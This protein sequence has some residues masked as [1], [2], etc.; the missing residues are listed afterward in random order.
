MIW[1]TLYGSGGNP[2]K[3]V[4]S[5]NWGDLH[6]LIELNS[7][8]F[9]INPGQSVIG[10]YIEE[11]VAIL[12]LDEFKVPQWLSI[13]GG[14]EEEQAHGIVVKSLQGDAI[15]NDVYVC[16]RTYSEDF[17]IEDYGGDF[18]VNNSFGN[19]NYQG[20][21]SQVSDVGELKWSTLVAGTTGRISL[22]DIE[23]S[24]VGKIFTVGHRTSSDLFE[25]K[26][27]AYNNTE[28][29]GIIV[30]F[31]ESNRAITWATGWNAFI[32]DFEFDEQ[33]RMY[34]SG[35]TYNN[36]LPIV[37]E[38]SFP[39]TNI[40]T[41]SDIYVTRLDPLGDIDFS[42]IAFGNEDCGGWKT[43]LSLSESGDLLVSGI[44]DVGFLCDLDDYEINGGYSPQGSSNDVII[45]KF[46]VASTV[47]EILY[48]G[49]FGS[50][51]NESEAM[52]QAISNEYVI[53]FGR[54]QS[55][56]EPIIFPAS[57]PI[58]YYSTNLPTDADSDAF[59]SM[60]NSEM[61]LVWSTYYGSTFEEFISG[62]TWV[63]SLNRLTICG[64]NFGGFYGIAAG[65]VLAEP[66]DNF[67]P[68][69]FNEF[70]FSDFYQ[71]DPLLGNYE[72]Q[73]YDLEASF[74]ASFE[75]SN[76]DVLSATSLDKKEKVKAWPNPASSVITFSIEQENFT[77][78]IYN[79]LGQRVYDDP[80]KERAKTISTMDWNP[81]V[82]IGKLTNEEF[83]EYSINF[84]VL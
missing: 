37:N 84:V 83:L 16:G 12:K 57:N 75:I 59:I 14:S 36:L 15:L 24:S 25:F 52:I 60:F 17:V 48:N 33:D 47:P 63:E 21:V 70:S 74:F 35:R 80:V 34:F 45:F 8:V 71:G 20:F 66:F 51:G 54:T 41:L 81:G 13:L 44:V 1:N 29:I 46:D 19:N 4:A 67:D 68:V 61:E 62:V 55:F 9:P 28:G 27:G 3:G 76:L 64:Y 42:F 78:E 31:N 39:G 49:F 22:K 50:T 38:P 58:N 43:S 77:L 65:Q 40:V 79:V 11:D 56:G 2:A 82:Y 30:E 18:I 72:G 6:F 10:D 73:E 53:L 5:N 7:S 32:D 23:I 26:E 69:D